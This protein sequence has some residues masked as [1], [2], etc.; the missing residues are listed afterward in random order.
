MGARR[1][2]E[3]GHPVVTSARAKLGG[4][5]LELSDSVDL[6]QKLAESPVVSECFARHAFRYFS[7][8]HDPAVEASFLASA[9][10]C[11]SR[12]ETTCSKP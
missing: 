11:R 10:A 12:V 5:E 3:H 7:A 4:Q 8:E 2:Q 9:S 1:E 6:V